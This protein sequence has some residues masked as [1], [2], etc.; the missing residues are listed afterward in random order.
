MGTVNMGSPRAYDDFAMQGIGEYFSSLLAPLPPSSLETDI[1]MAA[2]KTLQLD[3]DSRAQLQRIVKR[4]SDW[5]ERERAQTLLLLDSGVFAEEVARQMGLS[6]RT[7]HI[8][9]TRWRQ[10]GMASLP[11]LPRSGAPKKLQPEH[12]ERLVQWATAEPLTSAALLA[13]HLDAGGP[14]VHVNTMAATL[15][16]SGLVWK[17]TRHSLKKAAAR[18]LSGKQP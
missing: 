3:D 17:R 11:D 2:R 6:A 13:R 18:T 8:T 12:V 10:S 1:T 14:K 15:K 9:H 16:A 4:A 7:V 5:R